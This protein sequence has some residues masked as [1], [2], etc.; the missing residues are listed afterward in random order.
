MNAEK[1]DE[2][3]DR[4]LWGLFVELVLSVAITF[5]LDPDDLFEKILTNAEAR[6]LIAKLMDVKALTDA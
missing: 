5:E 4:R 1:L 6:A 2:T 3:L